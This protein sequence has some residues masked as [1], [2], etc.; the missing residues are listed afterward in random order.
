MYLRQQNRLDQVRQLLS[1]IDASLSGIQSPSTSPSTI[2][3]NTSNPV[4]HLGSLLSHSTSLFAR[5]Q[6]SVSRLSNSLQQESS[7]EGDAR[8]EAQRLSTQ[9]SPV[10][11]HLGQLFQM[12][13]SSLSSVQLGE[14]PG[15]VTYTTKANTT[16]GTANSSTNTSNSGAIQ[17]VQV[18]VPLYTVS[19]RQPNT[20]NPNPPTNQPA[21]IV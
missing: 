11:Q 19:Q 7:L 16:T 20:V 5:I 15:N 4:E 9:L 12:L 18:S 6:P 2:P 21:G 17:P 14:K 13:S 8:R 3:T 1:G 10:F